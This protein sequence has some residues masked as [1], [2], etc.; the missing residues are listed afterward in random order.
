MLDISY[1]DHLLEKA[2]DKEPMSDRELRDFAAALIASPDLAQEYALTTRITTDA[3]RLPRSAP[4][5]DFSDRIMGA[6]AHVPAPAGAIGQ[7]RGWIAAVAAVAVVAAGAVSW[8]S[9]PL[10]SAWAEL[11]AGGQTWVAAFS[12]VW[13]AAAASISDWKDL[14]QRFLLARW[15]VWLALALPVV[16]G[17]LNWWSAQGLH[18]ETARLSLGDER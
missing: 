8:W 6:I 4:S 2:I 3:A 17:V 9:A 7:S 14:G 5:A 11:L 1:Q 12:G 15:F 18:G 13:E 10:A 16:A